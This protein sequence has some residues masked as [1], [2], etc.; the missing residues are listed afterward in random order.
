MAGYG[1]L[2]LGLGLVVTAATGRRR[3]DV[4]REI[5]Q[6]RHA[7]P[8]L[9][10]ARDMGLRRI[11]EIGLADDYLHAIEQIRECMQLRH[12]FAHCTWAD[13]FKIKTLFYTSLEEAAAAD[14]GFEYTWRRL[15]LRFWSHRRRTA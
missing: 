11:R 3:D 8:R 13:N 9:N 6:V 2:E 1:E 15:D 10:D 4:L 12:T 14:T 5:F 7:T